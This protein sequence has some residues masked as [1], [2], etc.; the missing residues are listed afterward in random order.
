MLMMSPKKRNNMNF[1]AIDFETA[2]RKRTS[3]CSI[4][5]AK[6]RD[7]KIVE[8]YYDLIQPYPNEFEYINISIHGITPEMVDGSPTLLDAWPG[9]MKFID[10][11]V[12][13]AHNVSFEQSVIN[14][15][16]LQHNMPIP[17]LEYLCT[18]YMSQVNYPRRIS[19]KLDDLTKDLLGR[20]VNHHH[21]LEDAIACADLAIHHIGKFREQDPREL[22]KVLY[23]TPISKKNEWKKL[24][25]TKPTKEELDPAHPFYQKKIVLT[26]QLDSMSREEAVRILVDCGGIYS[27]AV[28]KQTAIVVY[29]DVNY[30]KSNFGDL[31]NKHRAALL[32]KESGH[33]IQVISEIEFKQMAI[34]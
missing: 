23:E 16:M 27:T 33:P 26:G 18:L 30:Q 4:G 2:N 21:A 9:I 5:L 31:S 29:G 14:Q 6:V 12:L 34:L 7:G 25:G 15:Y 1:T 20:T 10:D 3:A 19:Y 32:L 11:D 22:I 13:V 17:T 28:S 24:T 8:T